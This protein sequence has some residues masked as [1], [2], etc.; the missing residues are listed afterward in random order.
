VFTADGDL[1]G[2]GTEL[3]G[4]GRAG[5]LPLLV[6]GDG[7]ALSTVDEL[8]Q[9]DIRLV[10]EDVN[11]LE[12]GVGSVLELDAEEVAEVGGITTAELNDDGR[13]V[14]GDS[15]EFGVLVSDASHVEERDEWLVGGLDQEEL[16]RV[17]VEGDAL[18]R[19]DDGVHH[20]PASD[21]ADAVDSLVREDTI[22]V[23]VSKATS[24]VDEGRRETVSVGLV[25]DE[26]SVDEIVDIPSILQSGGAAENVV[27]DAPEEVLG[28]L[29][30]L[31]ELL[32]GVEAL[33]VLLESGAVSPALQRSVI[34]RFN[35][36]DRDVLVTT[37]RG[38]D[39]S[40]VGKS[41]LVVGVGREETL[42]NSDGGVEDD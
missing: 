35:G 3:D 7:S 37:K 20:S 38:S 6:A 36:F 21:V 41:D 2:E 4:A 31:L 14:V 29:L 25:V 33:D 23:E 28:R 10:A 30:S 22:L 11:I 40:L 5:F 15:L 42:E 17:A 27:L 13:R 1:S 24:L 8:S 26:L 32:R 12:V 34:A 19:G 18:E 39:G 16:E 9:G